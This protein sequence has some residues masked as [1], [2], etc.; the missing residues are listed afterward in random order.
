MNKP[1]IGLKEKKETVSKIIHPKQCPLCKSTNI[2]GRGIVI[3]YAYI[4]LD[5][6]Q[7]DEFGDDFEICDE[8]NLEY[9]CFVC[10]NDWE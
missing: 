5:N 9:R 4:N 3:G 2:I 10:D 8:E 1:V 7:V 6:M